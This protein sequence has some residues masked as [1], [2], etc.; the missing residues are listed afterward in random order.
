MG[1][2]LKKLIVFCT[3]DGYDGEEKNIDEVL[4]EKM[5]SKFGKE[6]LEQITGDDI[7]KDRKEKKILRY[8][9]SAKKI[10]EMYRRLKDTGYCSYF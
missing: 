10:L 4:K 8:H 6:R 9:D 1:D 7:E 3:K 5:L 2:V